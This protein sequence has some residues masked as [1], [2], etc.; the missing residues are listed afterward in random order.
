MVNQ[1]TLLSYRLAGAVRHPVN[2]CHTGRRTGCVFETANPVNPVFT[3]LMGDSMGWNYDSQG[4]SKGIAH[5][6]RDCTVTNPL[7]KDRVCH[8][9]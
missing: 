3:L 6:L 7:V 1:S 5:T 4:A 8:G 2:G 9:L